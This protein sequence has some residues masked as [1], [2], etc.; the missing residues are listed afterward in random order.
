M[1]LDSPTC[2][3]IRPRRLLCVVV[4]RSM[5]PQ[6]CKAVFLLGLGDYCRPAVTDG[7][8]F[9]LGHVS[10]LQR[11]SCRFRVCGFLICFM[12]GPLRRSATE[13][14]FLWTSKIWCFCKAQQ[15]PVS[16]RSVPGQCP[17]SARSMP[18]TVP[19]Q[20]FLGKNTKS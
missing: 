10:V 16:A 2:A 13:L 1:H 11:R 6:F 15:C 8:R 17:V 20:Y 7:S 9:C 3:K 12:A 18:G 19:G 5:A 4:P 14:Q